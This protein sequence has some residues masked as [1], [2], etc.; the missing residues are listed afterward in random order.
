[1]A[2]GGRAQVLMADG[3]AHAWAVTWRWHQA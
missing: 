2:D 1:L 3:A